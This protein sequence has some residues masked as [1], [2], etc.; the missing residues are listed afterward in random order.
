MLAHA[1][2][3]VHPSDKER[4]ILPEYPAGDVRANDGSDKRTG[5]SHL[6]QGTEAKPENQAFFA[7]FRQK[8]YQL[9]RR[10]KQ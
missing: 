1:L 5:P 3:S 9:E 4:H 10:A 7:N 6:N 8:P 2:T